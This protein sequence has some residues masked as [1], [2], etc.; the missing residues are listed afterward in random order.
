MEQSLAF[1]IEDQ[2]DNVTLFEDVLQLVGYRVQYTLD[3]LSAMEW[4]EKNEAPRLIVLDL[5]LPHLDGHEIYRYIRKQEQFKI[6]VIIVVTANGVMADEIRPEIA[7]NDY[8]FMKP[9]DVMELM[10]IAKKLTGNATV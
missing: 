3:G 6:S 9:I 5:N 1:I 4:L 7:E 2:R 10:R 8:L